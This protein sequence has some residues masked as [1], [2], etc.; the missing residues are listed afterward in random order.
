MGWARISRRVR[1]G[2]RVA[3]QNSMWLRD[4]TH[5]EGALPLSHAAKLQTAYTARMKYHGHLAYHV[6]MQTLPQHEQATMLMEPGPPCSQT[7]RKQQHRSRT[8]VKLQFMYRGSM[9]CAHTA[10]ALDT[11]RIQ[12][13]GCRSSGC[14][15][16]HL[17]SQL[18]EMSP[19]QVVVVNTHTTW[20]RCQQVGHGVRPRQ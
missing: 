5:N 13:A 6:V 16:H 7:R 1:A 9:P 8:P 11:A 17:S 2:R 18:P 3:E 4:G 15:V 10:E 19:Q 12:H 14:A 20:V